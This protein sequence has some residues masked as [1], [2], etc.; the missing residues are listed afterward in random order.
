M[1]SLVLMPKVGITVE[2]CVI[3]KWHKQKGDSV[4][5]GDILFSYE[6]DKA[7]IDEEA[8]EDGVL[9]DIFHVEGDDVPCL[10]GVAVIGKEGEDYSDLIPKA[11]N[12]EEAKSDEGDTPSEPK[13]AEPAPSSDAAAAATAEKSDN[14]KASPRAKSYAKKHGVDLRLVTP[15][16]PYGRIVE[17]DVVK[18][19]KDGLV[20]TGAALATGKDASGIQGTG[21]GGRVT[22]ADLNRAASAPANAEAETPEVEIVKL[23]NIRKVIAKSMMNSLSTTAQLTNHSSFDATAIMAYRKLLKATDEQMGLQKITLNDFILFAVSRAL[24]NHRDLNAHLINDEM[25]YFKGVHIGIAVDTPRGLL[26]PTLFN[27]DKMSL[28]EI[29]ENAK[30]LINKTKEGTIEPDYLQ[31]ASF[32]VTNLGTLGVESFT[33]VINP[34]QTGILG[35][36]SIV[37]KIKIDGDTIKPYKSMGLSLTFDHRAIDGA[38]AARFMMELKNILEN[39]TAYLAK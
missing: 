21:I 19:E 39:F 20:L 15:T 14:Y 1:A 23:S 5:A 25:H 28:S 3:T 36:S 33:P 2:S 9:L 29:S 10:E 24:K 27:A 13:E 8:K 11:E 38:P 17:A 32:T 18:A 26:V 22:V 4:K 6:T 7:S 31:G 12:A 35:V 34:P 37:D 30:I 16:G